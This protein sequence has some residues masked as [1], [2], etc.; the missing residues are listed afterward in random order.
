MNVSALIVVIMGVGGSSNYNNVLNFV[1]TINDDKG[2]ASVLVYHSFN[3]R[4]GP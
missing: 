4:F 3:L 1:R 2:M